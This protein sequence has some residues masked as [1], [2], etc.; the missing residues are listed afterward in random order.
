M[1]APAPNLSWTSTRPCTRPR[2]LAQRSAAL[3]PMCRAQPL[4]ASLAFYRAPGFPSQSRAQRMLPPPA[5]PAHDSPTWP[6]TH[7]SAP[8]L[9]SS[10]PPLSC[11][12]R[13]WGLVPQH[14]PEPSLCSTHSSVGACAR[15][16]FCWNA[17]P[18]GFKGHLS[19]P[20]LCP[21]TEDSLDTHSSEIRVPSR[22]P[23][24]ATQLLG[25]VRALGCLSGPRPAPPGPPKAGTEALV[26]KASDRWIPDIQGGG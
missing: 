19:A 3:V 13:P 22:R 25:I 14:C 4:C 6:H 21:V 5:L 11:P 16:P 8:A 10:W 18:R 2:G 7:S 15:R 20:S 24:A 23:R 1:P 17:H 26:T 12:Q 9:A